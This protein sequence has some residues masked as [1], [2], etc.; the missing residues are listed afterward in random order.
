MSSAEEIQQSLCQAS[1]DVEQKIFIV[2]CK[3]LYD[4]QELMLGVYSTYPK[5]VERI[6]QYIKE[7]NTQYTSYRFTIETWKMNNSNKF[8]T[9]YFTLTHNERWAKEQ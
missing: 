1:D 3:S 8:M 7:L 5:A 2:K 4:K 6:K 9:E